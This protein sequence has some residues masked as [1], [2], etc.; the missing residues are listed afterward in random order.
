M[1]VIKLA[2]FAGEAPRI[3]PRLLPDTGAQ[4]AQS[5][6]LEDGELVPTRKPFPTHTLVG[7]TGLVRTIYK[8]LGN[9]LAWNTVVNAVPGP[10][11]QDRLYYTGDGTPKM[12]VSGTEYELKVASPT[13]ALTATRVGSLGSIFSTRLYV[14][15]FVTDFGEESE[16]C[17]IS[18]AL[19]VSPGNTVTLSGFQAAPAGRAISKQRIYRSQTGT[20]GG[21][22]L[23]FLAERAAS[24]GN[25]SDTIAVGD[26]S[27]PIPSIDYN[28]P[29]DELSGLVAMPN[30]MMAAFKGKD[31]Y[32]CEPWQPHA[33]PEKYIQTVD[34]DIVAL[35]MCGSTLVVGTKGV[36]YLA[37]GTH[38]DSIVMDKTELNMPCLNSNGMVDLG[39]AAVFPSHDGLVMFQ[40]GGTSVPSA[41]L[42]TRD[43]WLRMDPATMVCGQFYGR[44]FASYSYVDSEGFTQQGTIILDLTGQSPFVIR[45]PYKADAMFYEKETGALYMVVGSV[46]YEWDSRQGINDI[47]TWKSKAFINPSP[48]NFGAI[49]FETDRRISQDAIDAYESALAAAIALNEAL[50]LTPLEA[51]INAAAINT[52]ALNGDLLQPLPSGPQANINIYADGKFYATVSKIGVMQRLPGGKLA[53]EWEIEVVG[54][55]S[56]VEIGMAT[57]GQELRSA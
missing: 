44:F 9:W 57:T 4:I 2:G 14:Y 21:T 10:V 33:W 43:Q 19:D 7:I 46:I 55:I 16:P 50:F 54:N 13:A 56:V 15:T 35:A 12:L 37:S 8:H 22:T 24:T 6:R 38:P 11:A 27:E 5:V 53:R 45:S 32:F 1:T 18:N 42:F 47:L 48:T 28:P 34:Y 40:G 17:P 25:Y 31:L 49:L 52:Y 41:G 51:E 36:L 39:Y 20:S 3:T 30:G 23:Y 29:P 26:F